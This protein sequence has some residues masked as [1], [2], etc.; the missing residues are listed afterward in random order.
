[1]LVE[2]GHTG[3]AN[4]GGVHEL[5]HARAHGVVLVRRDGD[6]SQDADDRDH[7]HELDQGE[8]SLH[9]LH[10]L[11]LVR[12][13]WYSNASFREGASKDA[14]RMPTANLLIPRASAA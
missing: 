11:L 12:S 13:G 8:T 3:L 2:L 6:G 1:R 4:A 7:D 14:T 10:S 9:V 5:G